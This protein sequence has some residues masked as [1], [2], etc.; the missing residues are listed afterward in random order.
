MNTIE[1]LTRITNTL[2]RIPT[3]GEDTLAMA[4]CLRALAQLINE[5]SM[6]EM[7]QGEKE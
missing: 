5:L 2:S 7:A 1:Q 3:R 4:D 6:Q